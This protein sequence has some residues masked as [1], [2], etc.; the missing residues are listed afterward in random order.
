[1]SRLL[2]EF[3]SS[4]WA[5]LPEQLHVMRM[6]LNRWESGVKLDRAEIDAAIGSA[7]AEAAARRAQSG[8]RG[9]GLLPV[10][11]VLAQRTAGDVSTAGTA[12]DTLKRQFASLMENEQVGA[13]VLDIDSPGGSVFGVQELADDIFAARGVKKVVAVANSLA[14]SAAY[15]IGTA[16]EELVVTPGGEVGSIGVIAAHEDHSAALEAEGIKVS[17]FTAGKYKGEGNPFGPMDDEAVAAL[18][19]RI[20]QYYA[21]F[22]GSVARH[23]DVAVG[24]VRGGFG[25]G[26]VVGAKD[27]VSMNMADRVATFDETI[28]RLLSSARAQSP[29]RN[30]AEAYRRQAEIQEQH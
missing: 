6:V 13:I 18:Q 26:R 3:Y 24:D 12:T 23:R 15:W 22:V 29:K 19:G 1:M 28:D 8:P 17:L 16:A 25:E 7:P 30:R 20:D 27:A 14:A 2:T 11:G 10:L 4:P 5:I 9:I 21:A